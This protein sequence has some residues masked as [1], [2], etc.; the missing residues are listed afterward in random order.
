[1]I[2][3]TA[4]LPWIMLTLTI[5]LVLT[6]LSLSLGQEPL[7]DTLL[8]GLLALACGATGA[9]VAS[10]QPA[11]PI[12]W[13]FCGLGVWGALLETWAAF[14]YHGLPTGAAGEWAISWSWI[15]DMAV[16]ALLFLIFPDGRLMTRR[17]RLV[18]WLLVA[19]CALAIPGQALSPTTAALS[20]ANAEFASGR[21]P[22]A[23]DSVVVQVAFIVGVVLVLAGLIASVISVVIRYR[24][25]TGV[26]RLQLKQFVF[27]GSVFIAAAV[28]A[29]PFYY[30]SIIVQVAAGLA[31]LALPI[32]AGLAILRYRLYDIDVVINRAL[33][34]LVL[35]TSLLL[36][37]VAVIIG[38]GAVLRIVSGESSSI[39]IVISTLLVAGLFRPLRSRIQHGV[40]RRFYRQRYNASRT[41]ERFSARMRDEIDIETLQAELQALVQ[42]TMQPTHVSMWLR[43]VNPAEGKT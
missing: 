7:S 33:V 11:N 40:D 42:E 28:I 20:P 12:G 25:A 18:L 41:L 19:G 8:F 38:V 26:E 4:R 32:A 6:M 3:A 39:A 23:V 27:A 13:V 21:N 43:P 2:R 36:V 34:Y 9:F 10:R 24:R 1:M 29:V 17:W 5:I 35:T 15:A 30:T 31:F 16:Y 14:A 22:L 37:Y